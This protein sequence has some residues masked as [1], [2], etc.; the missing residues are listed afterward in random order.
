[1]PPLTTREP[2]RMSIAR[3]L[4][5]AAERKA[6][7]Q[8]R[9]SAQQPGPEV[10]A[11]DTAAFTFE[12]EASR[13]DRQDEPSAQPPAP[14]SQQDFAPSPTQ[15]VPQGEPARPRS[16]PSEARLNANRANSQLSTGP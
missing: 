2:N 7:K 13:D 8:A 16:L 5:R 15:P 1:M 11:A 12:A 3:S 9:N 4:R 14:E 6:K 10:V